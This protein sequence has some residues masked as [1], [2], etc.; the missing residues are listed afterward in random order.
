MSLLTQFGMDVRILRHETCRTE[1]TDQ[2]NKTLRKWWGVCAQIPNGTTIY[3]GS[4]NAAS[5]R[6]ITDPKI[7]VSIAVQPSSR[8]TRNTLKWY[9]VTNDI[10]T[11]AIH[12]EPYGPIIM[13][14]LLFWW[15]IFKRMNWLN[16][17]TAYGHL[18]WSS[19]V[20]NWSQRNEYETG[21]FLTFWSQTHFGLLFSN[22]NCVSNTF[23]QKHSGQCSFEIKTHRGC[24]GRLSRK[25]RLS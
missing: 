14:T 19:I 6:Y 25:C 4:V 12:P 2:R 7:S 15:T 13:S 16:G 23:N 22:E 21:I 3:W 10:T 17:W 11:V 24:H 9:T 1:N 20:S 8:W 18:Q 5:T